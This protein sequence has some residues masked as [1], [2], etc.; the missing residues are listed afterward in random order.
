V[1][2]AH[3]ALIAAPDT[4]CR[5]AGIRCS[6]LSRNSA[7]PGMTDRVYGAKARSGSSA[8]VLPILDPA[9]LI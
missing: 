7:I 8:L 4:R 3:G 9:S 6:K 5:A 1:P 2:G